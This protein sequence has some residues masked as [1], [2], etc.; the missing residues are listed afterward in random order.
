MNDQGTSLPIRVHVCLLRA[1]EI[2]EVRAAMARRPAGQLALAG[3]STDGADAA[4][5]V[6]ASQ[7]DVVIVGRGAIPRGQ[8]QQLGGLS[9]RSCTRRASAR[10][11]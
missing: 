2:Q 7:P 5:Q 11:C 10:S 9:D 1:A 6:A 8:R 4:A 3:L